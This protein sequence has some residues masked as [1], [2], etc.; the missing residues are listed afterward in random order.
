MRNQLAKNFSQVNQK[1]GIK[2]NLENS[3]KNLRVFGAIWSGIFLLIAYKTSW[4]LLAIILAILFLTIS[5]LKPTFFEQSKILPMWLKFGEFAG[6]INSQ[7]VIFVMFYFLFTPIGI[8]LRL[9]GKDLLSKK[10]Q[11]QLTSYFKA[12]SQTVSDMRNQF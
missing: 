1:S 11:P 8:V 2:H 6:K 3:K 10:L 4:N 9:M 12:R 7:I 5:L